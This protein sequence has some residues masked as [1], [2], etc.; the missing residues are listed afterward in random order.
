MAGNRMGEQTR[1]RIITAAA[2]EFIEKGFE[3]AKME[4]IA[5]RAGVTK[6]MLYYHFNS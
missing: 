3:R 1:E 6:V 5:A 2:E 4:E